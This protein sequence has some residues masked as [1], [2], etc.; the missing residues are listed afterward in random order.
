MKYLK[1]Y[2]KWIDKKYKKGD[3][4]LVYDEQSRS[5]CYVRIVDDISNSSNYYMASDYNYNGKELSRY[6]IFDYEIVR[7]LTPDEIEDIKAKITARKYNI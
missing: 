3:Y 6:P 4:I 5:N 2:E 7:K 1:T